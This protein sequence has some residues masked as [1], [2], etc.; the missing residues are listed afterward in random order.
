MTISCAMWIA[1]I[2]IPTNTGA[3]SVPSIGRMRRLTASGRLGPE[4]L[5]Y[6][7]RGRRNGAL[8]AGLRAAQPD[9][10]N[11]GR[12]KAGNAISCGLW[13]SASG[14]L[15]IDAIRGPGGSGNRAESERSVMSAQTIRPRHSLPVNSD[16]FTV[17]MLVAF[18]MFAG[19]LSQPVL[20]LVGLYQE[21]Q[22]ARIAVAR[23]GDIMNMPQ[24]PYSLI[25][26]RA[27]NPTQGGARIDL[28]DLGFRYDDKQPWLYRHM[29]LALPAGKA[30]AIMGPSGAGKSTL[31]KLLQGFFLPQ[32]G[33]ILI[34]GTD[35]RHLSANELRG[36]FGVVPQE[37]ILFSGTLYDNLLAANPHAGFEDVV[38]ACRMAEIHDFIEGLPGGY[39][40]EVG[41]RGVGLSGGQRQRIAIARALLKRPRVL[42]FDE[43]TSALDPVTAEHLA[44]TI[45]TLKGAVTM[46]FI[47]HQ[48]PKALNIDGV[49]KIAPR[50]TVVTEE[51]R[52]NDA[53]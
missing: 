40:T 32:E 27:Q 49:V 3:S 24:E 1:C 30:L 8:H 20:K 51:G 31:A 35:L 53:E 6:E 38:T 43:A 21:L 2:S 37:T 15:P 44:R 39:Q 16:G 13:R 52:A 19:R 17:G 23:L 48:L 14:A 11:F 18:Q 50:P 26:A 25:P 12:G 10:Q 9:L 47:A 22:Q 5:G 4:D 29:N 45:N 46:L 33:R 42:I 28:Q 34:D 7:M 36:H 41:E